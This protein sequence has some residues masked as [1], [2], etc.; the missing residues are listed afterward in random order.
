M[1]GDKAICAYC[2]KEFIKT[3]TCHKYCS[4]RC[5]QK[6]YNERHREERNK[7]QREYERRKYKNGETRAYTKPIGYNP[8]PITLTTIYMTIGAL[9]KGELIESIEKDTQRAPGSLQKV[10]AAIKPEDYKR[11]ADTIKR[12]SQLNN[13]G[14]YEIPLMR[15]QTYRGN[16]IYE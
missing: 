14:L 7:K 9:E 6:A 5:N 16:M 10:I 15:G 13:K 2:G 8:A 12:G 4:Q 3:G 11:I 1:K